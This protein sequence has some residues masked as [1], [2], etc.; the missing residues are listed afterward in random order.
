M[1]L[2]L[3]RNLVLHLYLF[4]NVVFTGAYVYKKINKDQFMKANNFLILIKLKF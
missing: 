2:N 3:I 1:Y 4:V